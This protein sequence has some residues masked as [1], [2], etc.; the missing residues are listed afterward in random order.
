LIISF[1]K[2]LSGAEINKD[3]CEIS[4]FATFR[5]LERCCDGRKDKND[6]NQTGIGKAFT[7]ASS[8]K[9]SGANRDRQD[10]PA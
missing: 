8:R 5:I 3:N 10:E 9:R 2:V 6:E 7:Q 1:Q 4:Q